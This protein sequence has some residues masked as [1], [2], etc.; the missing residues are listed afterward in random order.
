MSGEN[1]LKNRGFRRR[2]NMTFFS[3]QHRT[4]RRGGARNPTGKNKD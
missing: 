2:L 3:Q 1:A 4:G